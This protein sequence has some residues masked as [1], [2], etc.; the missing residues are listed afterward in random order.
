MYMYILAFSCSGYT[1]IYLPSPPLRDGRARKW[2]LPGA[3]F[4]YAPHITYL[5]DNNL[6]SIPI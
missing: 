5:V 1:L 4:N 2:A 3:Q 6:L